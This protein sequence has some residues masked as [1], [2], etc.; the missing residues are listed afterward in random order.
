MAKVVD[1]FKS[2]V[3]KCIKFLCLIVDVFQQQMYSLSRKFNLLAVTVIPSSASDPRLPPV[4]LQWV[5]SFF[6]ESKFSGFMH[7]ATWNLF[8]WFNSLTHLCQDALISTCKAPGISVWLQD[9]RKEKTQWIVNRAYCGEDTSSCSRPAP[10]N[11]FKDKG[12][13]VSDTLNSKCKLNWW[14]FF[15]FI[16]VQI[17]S[18]SCPALWCFM[19]ITDP[20]G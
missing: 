19:V 10:D 18:F 9:E 2:A 3:Y 20:L 8:N 16:I 4:L 11:Y 13:T 6:T 7:L 15:H 5:H 14:L 12:V 17:R 1:Y